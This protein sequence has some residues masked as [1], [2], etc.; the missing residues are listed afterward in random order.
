[1]D[2]YLYNQVGGSANKPVPIG[3]I[4]S[5]KRMKR[6]QPFSA[7]VEALKDSEI[8]EIVGKDEIRRKVPLEDRGEKT[9][10]EFV[11]VYEDRTQS[12]SVY[13]KGFG[14]E[15]S[16]TQFDIED[17]FA[18]YGPINAV[19]LRRSF[20]EKIFKGS[21]FIEF[22]D[23][24]TQ[25]AFM[26][27]DPK[28]KWKGQDLLIMSKKDYVEMKAEDI[29]SGK[30]KP[31]QRTFHHRGGDRRSGGRDRDGGRG[32]DRD[33]GRWQR[34]R[35][36]R[37]RDGERHTAGTITCYECGEEGHRRADCPN[38]DKEPQRDRSRQSKREGEDEF[39]RLERPDLE[40]SDDD[41]T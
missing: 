35:G 12:R 26:D 28:P 39:G 15:D 19:R 25:K 20:P 2:P 29:R 17:F 9:D 34:G 33:G 1:M 22:Y 38:K 36:G 10:R 31:N 41:T 4:H 18:P 24:D 5:F 7:V 13:A 8:L 6:F 16:S 27:L 11:Q 32:R 14:E 23:E 30:I 21:V 40:R 3:L 37:F